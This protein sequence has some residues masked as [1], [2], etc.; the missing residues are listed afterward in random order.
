MRAFFYFILFLTL[1]FTGA[2][3]ATSP[4]A[5][6]DQKILQLP[7]QQSQ[8]VEQL[9]TY[10]NQQFKTPQERVRAAYVWLAN[11][12]A[13]DVAALNMNFTIK[14]GHNFVEQ[15]LKTRKAICQGYAETFQELCQRAGVKTFFVGGYTKQLGRVE[16]IPHAWCA[17]QLDGQWYLFD[18]TWGAGYVEGNTFVK[19]YN[20]QFFMVAPAMMIKS[21]YPFDPLWQFSTLPI[22]SKQFN[23]GLPAAP[24]LKIRFHYTDTLKAYDAQDENQRLAGTAR[25]MQAHGVDHAFLANYLQHLN[26]GVEI[27]R[28]NA[29][30]DTYN[31]GIDLLNQ[32]T[33]YKNKKQ[34]SQKSEAELRK[35]LSTSVTNLQEAKK[36]MASTHWQKGQQEMAA[37]ARNIELALNQ[38]LSQEVYLDRYFQSANIK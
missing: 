8:S 37:F 32:F 26:Q 6:V 23:E 18:P 31:R 10:I 34:L 13:Y 33:Y 30:T 3:Q 28:Y 16:Y 2:A 29:I 24:N 12:V 25:R 14:K 36:Q 19:K 35:M 38:A 11:N 22:T 20:E 7:A 9:S 5:H 17:A 15:T 21:H 1:P 4:F 27:D